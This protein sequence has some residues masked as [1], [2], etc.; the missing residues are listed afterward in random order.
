MEDNRADIHQEGSVKRSRWGAEREDELANV[1]PSRR[2]LLTD[3]DNSAQ[4]QQNQNQNQ[5]TTSQPPPAGGLFGS[6]ATPQPQQQQQTG[7]GGGLFG[8]TASSQPQQQSGS[9]FGG[10]ATSQPQQQQQASELFGSNP[11]TSQPQQSGSLFG[12]ATSQPQQ[13]GSLFGSNATSQPQPAGSL[14]GGAASNTQQQQNTSGTGLFGSSLNPPQ[15]QQQ[16]QSQG[17]SIFGGGANRPATGLFGSSTTGNA[18]TGTGSS[19]FGGSTAVGGGG[20][21]LFGGANAQQPQQQQ[22]GNSLFGPGAQTQQQQPTSSIFGLT[23][24]QPTFN[25]PPSLLGASQYRSSQYPSFSGRLTLGQ[26]TSTTASSAEGQGAVKIN[27]DT[28]RPTTRF[29]DIIPNV[30]ED[31]ERIDR[32]I[33]TQ[34]KYCREIKAFIPK[35]GDDVQS[36]APDVEFVG[37]KAEAVEAALSLDAQNTDSERKVLD[38]DDRDGERLKRVIDNQRMPAQFRYNSYGQQQQQQHSAGTTADDGS[39]K[40][41]LDL[42]NN[43]FVPLATDLQ[44]TLSAYSANLSE[45]ES[46]MRVMEASVVGQAQTLAARRAGVAA[47]ADG[48]DTVADLADTLRGFEASILGAAGLVGQCRDGVNELVLGRLGR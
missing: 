7:T 16:Q 41:D 45:I 2:A 17:S 21:S 22:Q 32:M 35:H 34:E 1:H 44:K 38:K 13:S 3:D 30:Q 20:S 15:Q 19:L 5:N 29:G 27:L 37:D 25:Q 4:Q 47:S 26:P 48:N 11:A 18:G 31:L 39:E 23:A 40:K 8:S 43:F 42:I 9:L 33:Q 28:L 46:H 24:T 6:T 10:A 36:L 12:G 14:F